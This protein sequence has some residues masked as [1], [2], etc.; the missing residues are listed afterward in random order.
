[1][2]N[3]IIWMSALLL[4]ITGFSSCSSD[5]DNFAKYYTWK[6]IEYDVKQR[7]DTLNNGW[8]IAYDET[9]RVNACMFFSIGIDSVEKL[10][11]APSC[12]EDLSSFYRIDPECEFRQKET[13][14]GKCDVYGLKDFNWGIVGYEL[15]YRGV[16]VTSMG[17]SVNYIDMPEGRRFINIFGAVDNINNMDVTPH[18]SASKALS[19]VGKYMHEELDSSW[20]ST[21]AINEFSF[22]DNNGKINREQRLIYEISGPTKN[23]PL[24]HAEVDAHTGEL[25]VFME[26]GYFDKIQ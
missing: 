24:Y 23:Y 21:L 26:Y 16:P 10:K 2:K 5:D 8:V 17:L 7:L 25:L 19:T 15:Y 20:Q 9:G 12:I 22:R 13:D 4:T 1:M 18:I 3:C 14:W 11:K 6:K